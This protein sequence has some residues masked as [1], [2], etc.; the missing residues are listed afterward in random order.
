MD[1]WL[2]IFEYIFQPLL[3]IKDRNAGMDEGNDQSGG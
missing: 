1:N 3:C 2:P